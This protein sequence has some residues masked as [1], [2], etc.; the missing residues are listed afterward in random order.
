MQFGA[1][2]RFVMKGYIQTRDVLEHA[3]L[4]VREFGPRCLVFCLWRA[5]AAGRPITFLECVAATCP[6]ST[7]P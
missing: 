7:R 2:E 6:V 1:D 3:G 4:I 5:I